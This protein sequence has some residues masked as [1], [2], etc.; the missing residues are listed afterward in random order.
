MSKNKIIPT[1][2]FSLSSEKT[3]TNNT[4][5]ITAVVVATID[6]TQTT[7][8]NV[9]TQVSGLL[10]TFIPDA[11][12]TFSN[13]QRSTDPSG[14]ESARYTAS[15]RVSEEINQN[16]QA[17]ADE[18]SRPGLSIIQNVPDYSIPQRDIEQAISDLRVVI[19]KE[20]TAEA[21]KLS[22]AAGTK[23][24][25]GELNFNPIVEYGN[26]A[27]GITISA[28]ASA[29]SAPRGGF[30]HSQKVSVTANVTLFSAKAAAAE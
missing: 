26:N 28:M 10:N 16:L 22:E 5:K 7:N 12:W 20:A 15:T 3:L 25:I 19:L 2:I 8:E 18:A 30:G 17:R 24:A 11:E 1:I 23:Y 13:P 14:F 4:V 9:A 21:K 27:R 29:E 6:G